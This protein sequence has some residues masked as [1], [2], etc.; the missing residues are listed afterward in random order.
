MFNT[1]VIRFGF[2]IIFKG[3]CVFHEARVNITDVFTSLYC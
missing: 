3:K 2:K 1:D